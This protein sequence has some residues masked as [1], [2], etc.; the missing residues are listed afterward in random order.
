MW[1]PNQHVARPVDPSLMAAPSTTGV[2]SP[3][4]KCYTEQ[5]IASDNWLHGFNPQPIPG[6]QEG[7]Q[8]HLSVLGH[9]TGKRINEQS[10]VHPGEAAIGNTARK[11]DSLR[12]KAAEPLS[13]R[14][15]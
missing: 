12:A 2:L 7:Y 6:K 4:V 5:R 9:R 11:K 1:T 14:E 15:I 8:D 10:G 13:S 3:S